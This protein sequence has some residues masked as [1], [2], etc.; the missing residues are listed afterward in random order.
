MYKQK[1]PVHIVLW[2]LTQYYY[3]WF[4]KKRFRP[5]HYCPN[6]KYNFALSK[7][8]WFIEFFSRFVSFCFYYTFYK[9]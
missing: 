3:T 1:F 5:I 2:L 9:I 7:F 4:F 8:D 6:S